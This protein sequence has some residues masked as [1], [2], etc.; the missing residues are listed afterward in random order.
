VTDLREGFD[1]R[2][3]VLRGRVDGVYLGHGERPRPPMTIKVTV[4]GVAYRYLESETQRSGEVVELG[5]VVELRNG[6]WWKAAQ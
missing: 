6:F 2:E 4:D 3:R 5:D 1:E